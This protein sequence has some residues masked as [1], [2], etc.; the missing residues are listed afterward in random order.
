MK[1]VEPGGK[2]NRGGESSRRERAGSGAS[3]VSKVA[4]PNAAAVIAAASF[5]HGCSVFSFPPA[6]FCTTPHTFSL[7]KQGVTQHG[8]GVHTSRGPTHTSLHC[9]PAV[10]EQVPHS[11]TFFCA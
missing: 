3:W 6:L 11:P 8:S 7:Q 4:Q 10:T 9:G 1:A 5:A 2:S